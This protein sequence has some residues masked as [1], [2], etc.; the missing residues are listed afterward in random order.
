MYKDL[1]RHIFKISF[2]GFQ[3]LNQQT[4]SSSNSQLFGCILGTEFDKN[5]KCIVIIN[6]IIKV[7]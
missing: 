2:D 3:E 1:I 4:F 5:I 7:V 6:Y